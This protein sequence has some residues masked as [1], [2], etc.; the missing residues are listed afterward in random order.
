VPGIRGRVL[1]GGKM[2][3]FTQG[4]AC[5]L[6]SDKEPTAQGQRKNFRM[7]LLCKNRSSGKGW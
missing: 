1:I 2:T 5:L 3:F 4:S 7:A 6:V